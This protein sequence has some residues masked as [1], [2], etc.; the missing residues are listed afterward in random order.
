[1]A[2]EEERQLCAA[3][4]ASLM[5]QPSASGA[6]MVEIAAQEGAAQEGAAHTASGPASGPASGSASAPA[7]GSV[8]GSASSR[9]ATPGPPLGL[10]RGP[11]PGL[12]PKPERP[13][14]PSQEQITQTNGRR[15]RICKYWAES[16]QCMW[17]AKCWFG[18]GIRD[19]RPHQRR[20]GESRSEGQ[21]DVASRP[22]SP[23]SFSSVFVI[24]LP[25]DAT[26]QLVADFF[27]REA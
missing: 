26:L 1:M 8:R 17:G 20:A 6:S 3:I 19:E 9:A 12:A 21:E 25:P 10:P 7:P 13:R 23:A 5:D 24:N 16:G 22:A 11:R 15:I 14:G 2:E 4:A 27:E 18:H